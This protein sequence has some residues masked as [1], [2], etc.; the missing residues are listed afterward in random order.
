M[1]ARRCNVLAGWQRVISS[2]L[3]HLAMKA[4]IS[5]NGCLKIVPESETEA[6]ALHCWHQSQ[7]DD[8][9]LERGVLHCA[10]SEIDSQMSSI[11][12]QPLH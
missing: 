4:T 10:Y 1:Q 6:Y 11:G 2:R 12:Y 5:A 3:E 7:S 8:S 9:L